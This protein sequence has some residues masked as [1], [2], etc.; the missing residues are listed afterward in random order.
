MNLYTTTLVI[1][2]FPV[3]YNV[4]WQQGNQFLLFKPELPLPNVKDY[5]IFWVTKQNGAWAPINVQD[6]Y[7][8]DQVVEDIRLHLVE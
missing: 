2:N 5:P 1:D 4:S 7:L 3:R 6:P 8:V